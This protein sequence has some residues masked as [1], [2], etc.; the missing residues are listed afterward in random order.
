MPICHG[1]MFEQQVNQTLSKT[2]YEPDGIYSALYGPGW[3]YYS[4]S[5]MGLRNFFP[6]FYQPMAN[7]NPH[8]PASH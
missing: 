4:F 8:L 1:N 5:T 6:L 7:Q 3:I 2:G